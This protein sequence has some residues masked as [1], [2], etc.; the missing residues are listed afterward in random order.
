MKS[1]RIGTYICWCGSNIANLV[2]VQQVTNAIKA[3]PHVII[4][5]DYRYMCSNPGQDMLIN[6][7]RENKLDRIVIAACSPRIHELTFRKALEK[8]GLNPYMLQMANI[9]EQNSWVHIDKNKA[10]EKAITLVAAAVK[11]VGFHE[12]LQKRFVEINPATLIIGGGIAGLTAALEIAN[13]GHTVYLVEQKTVLGGQAAQLNLSYPDFSN[14]KEIMN[15][16]IKKTRE[17]KYIKIYTNVIL[18]EIVGYIGNF[19]TF[20]HH[21]GKEVDLQF[22]NII[23]ATGLK[24]FDARAIP[25]YK[26]KRLPNII[27][28]VELEELFIRG[29]I[30][31]ADGRTPKNI[32]IIHCVGSRNKKYL[33]YC[34]RICCSTA[35]KYLNQLRTMFPKANLYDIYADMRTYGKGCEE[36]YAATSMKDIMFL[37]FDQKNNLPE[38]RT[39]EQK[40]LII[41]FKELL[42]GEEIEVP[43]DLIILM[44]GLAHQSDVK[45][46]AH[47]TGTSLDSNGFF[48]EKHAKLDPVAT[49]TDGVFLAGNC[50]SPKSLN[51]S[52]NQAKAA[53]ARVL[54]SIARKE[55]EIEVTTSVVNENVCCGCKTCV[56][57]CPYGAI[58]FQDEKN[59]SGVNEILCKGCG[60]CA[61]A[62][63]TGAIKCKHFTDQQIISQI[64]G[65]LVTELKTTH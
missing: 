61:S 17:N 48:I 32:A 3:L 28:S 43:A 54:S 22:G 49:T 30:K 35:L 9:R 33:P 18:N 56:K 21:N 15:Q 62:C 6:D 65:L 45:D 11:R 52:I 13:S 16:L 31:L 24:P 23:I 63:P 55:V 57:V 4:S 59:V 34:S 39:N 10:T 42:S 1:P 41:E 44:T 36:L 38:I 47:L 50:Q 51:E 60:T 29:E 26:Y 8:A 12:A 25:E 58:R 46:V 27:T 14:G 20:F 7:I 40:D 53:A 5:K 64:E 37:M 19:T 2:D